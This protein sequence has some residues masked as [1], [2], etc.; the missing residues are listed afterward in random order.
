[1]ARIGPNS[2]QSRTNGPSSLNLRP[3]SLRDIDI[4]VRHRRA[5][6]R[7]LHI[8]KKILL[9]KAD[10]EYAAWA[11]ARL[12]DSQLKA[13]IVKDNNGKIAGSGCL[14]L[15]SIQPRPGNP[16]KVQ[17][18]LL[19]MYTEPVF[20]RRGVAS[21]IVE[22]AIGWSTKNGHNRLLLHASETGR[23]VCRK[24]GF[25]RTWEMRLRLPLATHSRRKN[26]IVRS[27]QKSGRSF[28]N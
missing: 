21:M 14:W 24:Y 22:E 11:R 23:K 4:L 20:R 16:S 13:W 6:W 9:D 10:K 1:M 26:V 8:R 2:R 3:A 28:S 12:R 18:Y 5:M 25:K 27:A 7:A 15:Q 17:P 19:S